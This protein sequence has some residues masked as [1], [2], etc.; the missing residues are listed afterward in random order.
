MSI[1]AATMT[2]QWNFN[3]ICAPLQPCKCI[4]VIEI[5]KL[6][7]SNHRH[8]NAPQS[9]M[10]CEANKQKSGKDQTNEVLVRIESVNERKTTATKFNPHFP[11]KSTTFMTIFGIYSGNWPQF[12]S[13]LFEE[14]ISF[15]SEAIQKHQ[16]RK[17]EDNGVFKYTNNARLSQFSGG[18]Q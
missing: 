3:H 2:T 1:N 4:Q 14:H 7:D 16:K 9:N 12:L 10:R 18:N 11:L 6:T 8:E 15:P 5:E 17:T 13:R